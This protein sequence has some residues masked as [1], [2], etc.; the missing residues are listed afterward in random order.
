MIISQS[1]KKDILLQYNP[2]KGKVAITSLLSLNENYVIFLDEMYDIKNKKF[3]GNV[4]ESFDNLK[5]FFNDVPRGLNENLI[6]IKKDIN[7]IVLLESKT[8]LQFLKSQ[9]ILLNEEGF[10]DWASQKGKEA[11]QGT[12]QVIQKSIQGAK[13]AYSKFSQ[14]EW[15]QALDIVKK[16]T[17]YLARKLR[18]ALYHPVGMVLDAILVASGIGKA[19]Q[20]V[21]WAI[22]VALDIY[23]LTTGQY[24]EGQNLYT[25]LLFTGVDMIGLVFAG[26]AAKTAKGVVGAFVRGFGKN[27]QTMRA[28]IQKS[29]AMIKIVDKIKSSLDKVPGLLS[30]ASQ[31]LATKS[32][33]IHKWVSGLIT[34]VSGFIKKIVDTLAYLGQGAIKGGA[35]VVSAPGKII[36]KTAQK[37]GASAPNAAKISQG[38]IGVGLAG[39][40]SY[41]LDG[42]SNAEGDFASVSFDDIPHDFSQ[43]L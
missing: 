33:T 15:M 6:Q 30:Q 12:K 41:G 17:L 8:Q 28:G 38:A 34:K 2:E 21:I 25:K 10:L 24:P 26:V 3:L 40:I 5:I 37:L 22:V 7:S 13:D 18:D 27:L 35:A 29:P 39:G 20:F 42:K 16:G 31:W 32:P 36:T 4:W 11:V 1:E 9:F 14:G 19:A 43:G 23:E